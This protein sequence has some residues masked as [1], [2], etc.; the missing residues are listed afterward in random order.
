[1]RSFPRRA[2]GVVLSLLFT[3]TAAPATAQRTSDTSFA[4]MVARLSEQ[5]GYF[6]SDNIVTNEASYLHVAS[7]LAKVGVHGGVYIGVGP[8]QN[9]SYIALIHP[10]VAFM[11]D[12]RRDNML[13]HLMYKSLFAMSRNRLEFLLHLLG[14][15]VPSDVDAWSN[16][17]IADI[18]AYVNSVHVDSQAV[19]STRRASNERIL[20]FG[21]PLTPRDRETID[22]YRAAFVQEG[23]ETRFSSLGRNNRFDYPSFGRL[24][25]ETDREGRRRSYLAD[26]KAFQ[27]VR[28][29]QLSDKIIPVVGNVAG[30]KAVR[31][32]GTYAL[33]HGLKVSA[34]YLSNVEQYLIGRD[35]GFDEYAKNVKTLPHDTTS[36]IIRSYFGRGMPHPLYVPSA[37]NVSV[38]MVETMSSFLRAYAAGELTSY[39][40][41]VFERFVK[42]N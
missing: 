7:Q 19:Q 29:M 27:Y 20:K 11:L 10:A 22:R 4:G 41:V 40:A 15:P 17:P 35:G 21:V 14:K 12:I 36:V 25:M 33:E 32:I 9:F 18:L 5:G 39:S 38:S 42:P 26:E 3:A 34:F 2:A 37:G 6:D 28:T 23:L 31:A 8:D 24:I 30:E 13:E 1:M 16:R